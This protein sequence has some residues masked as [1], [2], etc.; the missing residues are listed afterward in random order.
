MPIEERAETGVLC[1]CY[2][3]TVGFL[4]IAK[5]QKKTKHNG[6]SEKLKETK[7]K[8]H[9]QISWAWNMTHFSRRQW[10]SFLFCLKKER[11]ISNLSVL[12]GVVAC[13]SFLISNAV[14]YSKAYHSSVTLLSKCMHY[15]P[16][17][18]SITTLC[19]LRPAFDKS[20]RQ[21][22]KYHREKKSQTGRG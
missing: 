11:T 6:T 21:L 5:T 20:N 13:S 7:T 10:S 15:A 19:V 1:I 16:W 8:S 18:N 14:Q 2:N 22:E 9:V 4:K 12:V 17:L 3:A